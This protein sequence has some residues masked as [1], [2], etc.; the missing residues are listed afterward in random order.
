MLREPVINFWKNSGKQGL[1][2]VKWVKQADEQ[3]A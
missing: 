3:K 2:H 1:P